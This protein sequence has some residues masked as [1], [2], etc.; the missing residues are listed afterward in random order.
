MS[1]EIS[2]LVKQYGHQKAVDELS[3]S[4]EKNEIVGFLGPNGA[5][6]ST[7]LKIATGYLTATSGAV[8]ISGL[9]VSLHPKEIKQRIGYLPEHNPLYLD[10]FVHEYLHFSG[11]FFNIK[12][13]ELRERTSKVIDMCQLGVEQNKKIGQLS[14]GY[15]QRVGLAQALLHEPEVLILDEPTT[16]LDPNQIIEVRELIKNI[17]I[18]R[19]V[20]FSTHIMQEVQ[21]ICDR[22]VI[23]NNGKLVADDSLAN[24]LAVSAK[25][26]LE[27]QFE[28]AVDINKLQEFAGIKYIIEKD[29]NIYDIEMVSEEDARP[30]MMKHIAS[31]GLPLIGIKQK[32]TTM[33]E[34]F[35]SLTQS[36]EHA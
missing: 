17:S 20:L 6:K 26:I 2:R 24:I 19:T 32:E 31:L 10:M 36:K 4:V 35:N 25:Q 22:V 14:K 5:G 29:N 21:A 7:T 18:E 9:D 27:I 23:I 1:I 15:R 11:R 34:V 16:G 13:K 8:K 33:E 3:F 30:E 12:G 28:A